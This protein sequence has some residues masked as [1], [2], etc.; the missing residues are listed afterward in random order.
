MPGALAVWLA[1]SEN[2]GGKMKVR[3]SAMADGCWYLPCGYCCETVTVWLGFGVWTQK[4]GER[5]DVDL[6]SLIFY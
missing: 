1:E 3:Y 5:G 2:T 4:Q 6:L